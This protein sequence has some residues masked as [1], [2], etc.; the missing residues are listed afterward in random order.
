MQLREISFF[1][2]FKCT[3]SECRHTCCRG[4]MIPLTAEDADRFRHE[5]GRLKLSLIAAQSD[6]D[7]LCFNKGSLE[8]PFHDRD[9]LCSLQLKR[10]HDFIPE[11][12]RMFPRFYRNY[13]S[14]EE[15]YIDPA[16]TEAARLMLMNA[17]N[18]QLEASQGEPLSLPCTTNDDEAFLKNMVN[19]RSAMLKR[20]KDVRDAMSLNEVLCDIYGYSS[21]L[22]DSF[23]N[24]D[25]DLLYSHP[26]E[27]YH[28]QKPLKLFPMDIG[29]FNDIMG[30]SFYH[31]RLKKTNP[32]LYR[33]CRLYFND[34]SSVLTNES[35]FG[36]AAD[37]FIK[38]NKEAVP[39]STAYYVYYLY[40]YF[41]KSY[42][43]YSF[44]RNAA[45]GMIHMNMIFMFSMLYSIADPSS[46][47]KILPDIISMY[48]RRACF[49]DEIMNE[50][51]LC[52]SR[53]L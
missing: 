28:S 31:E 33:L 14:F 5:K 47:P 38:N 32:F 16:C 25:G 21:A 43:D 4:W 34:T 6:T 9:G 37:D 19:A 15:H 11:A 39:L 23:L 45:L 46:Y 2:Q 20:L 48:D 8:C 24:G 35:S 13:I 17:G 36:K 12:C 53:L 27:S 52:L 40:L 30:T 42:E 41:L 50:M 7:I 44:V 10:G 49:N 29:I 3:G 26:F 1:R 18:M 22:Q 51:Y